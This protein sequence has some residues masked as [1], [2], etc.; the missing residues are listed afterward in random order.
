[1][2]QQTSFL[3]W[4]NN[5][6]RKKSGFPVIRQ[7]VFLVLC[8]QISEAR[9]ANKLLVPLYHRAQEVSLSTA[10]NTKYEVVIYCVIHQPHKIYEP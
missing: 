3:R 5:R 7:E 9:K 10:G 8:L 1:M 4:L 6:L 2:V